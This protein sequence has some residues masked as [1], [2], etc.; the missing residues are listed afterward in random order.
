MEE[1]VVEHA[2]HDDGVT[3]VLVEQGFGGFMLLILCDQ[4][5]GAATIRKRS[6]GIPRAISVGL[7]LMEID[8]VVFTI[9][10]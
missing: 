9:S 2:G 6:D 3:G 7:V 5:N 8:A 10:V 4:Q 1:L